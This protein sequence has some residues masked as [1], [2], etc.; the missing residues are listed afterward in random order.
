MENFATLD[1]IKNLFRPLTEDE[2]KK[3][4]ALLPIVS[5]SIRQEAMKVGKN[6]E[7]MISTGVLLENVVKSVTVDVVAR[8]LMTSTNAEPMSQ[9]SQSALGF[10]ISGT[11]LVPGGGLFIKKSELSRLGLKRQ[12]CG[13]I[14][15]YVKGNNNS[16]V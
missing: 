4:E 1:D 13:V 16:T 8:A 10:S 2:I 14:D 7:N 9:M 12:Q 11:Y 3:A 5:D 6:I 15:L